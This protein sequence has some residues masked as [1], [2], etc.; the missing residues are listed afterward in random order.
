MSLSSTAA[1]NAASPSAPLPLAD[2]HLPE[3]PSFSLSWQG[4]GFIFL[5]IACI[6]LLVWAFMAYRKKRRLQRVALSELAKLKPE[7]TRDVA[8]LLK[9]AALSHFSRQQIAA[10]HGLAWWNFIEQKLPTKKQA[11]VH[12]ATRSEMLEKALYGKVPLSETNQKRFYDDVRYWL[13]HALPA[14][15]QKAVQGA[16]HD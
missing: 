9:Q 11:N 14:K 7:Q 12:F 3:A 13:I 16:K 15:Q 5:I 10:L 2:L 6:A 1:P 4:Y 8:K